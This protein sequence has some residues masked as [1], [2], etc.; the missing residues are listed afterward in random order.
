[1]LFFHLWTFSIFCY[2]YL[3]FLLFLN[4]S[5]LSPF[6]FPT[7][8][9]LQFISSY[10]FSLGIYSGVEMLLTEKTSLTAEEPG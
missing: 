10:D 3:F 9:I 8:N 5:L 1:M 4:L 2:F 7:M 6:F